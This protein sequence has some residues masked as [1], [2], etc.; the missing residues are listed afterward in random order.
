MEEGAWTV[1][2]FRCS[3]LSL[4]SSGIM[5]SQPDCLIKGTNS[6]S[7]SP[8][9]SLPL[10]LISSCIQHWR[11]EQ[12]SGTLLALSWRK[13]TRASGDNAPTF[14]SWPICSSEI[15]NFSLHYEMYP[16]FLLPRQCSTDIILF[17]TSLGKL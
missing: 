7:Q 9:L 16:A 8:A 10:L 4:F 6:F 14:S 1:D 17:F 3:S 13:N 5:I 11:R 15:R 2:N 12:S